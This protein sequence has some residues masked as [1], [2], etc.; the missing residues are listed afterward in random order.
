MNIVLGNAASALCALLRDV[1]LHGWGATLRL[2]LLLIT[3][4]GALLSAVLILSL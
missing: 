2:A 4:A 1:A 3:V